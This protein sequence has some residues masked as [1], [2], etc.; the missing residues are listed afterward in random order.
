MKW[1]C[2]IGTDSGK[3]TVQMFEV[4]FLLIFNSTF[5]M[6]KTIYKNCTRS[7]YLFPF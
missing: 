6:T 3:I 5:D 4:I 1:E 7:N 2:V